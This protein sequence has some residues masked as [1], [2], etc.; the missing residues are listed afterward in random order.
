MRNIAK[1]SPLSNV[2]GLEAAMERDRRFFKR[3]PFLAEYSREIMPGEFPPS[4]MPPSCE[5]HGVVIVQQ[6][7]PGVRVRVLKP[8]FFIVIVGQP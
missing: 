6:I 4:E 3:H 1:N 7:A 8:D 2:C 5:A